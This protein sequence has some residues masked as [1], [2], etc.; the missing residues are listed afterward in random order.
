MVYVLPAPVCVCACVCAC[1]YDDCGREEVQ[2]VRPQHGVRLACTRLRVH[3]CMC[4]RVRACMH[5]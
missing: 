4:V 1:M 5:V 3:M 2:V